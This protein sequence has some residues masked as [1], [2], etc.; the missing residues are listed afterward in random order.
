MI[1]I[2]CCLLICVCG[3]FVLFLYYNTCA[4]PIR[5]QRMYV[6]QPKLEQ[7]SISDANVQTKES[8]DSSNTDE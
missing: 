3:W 6:Q 5:Q 7:P 1:I 4:M 8:Q 2:G